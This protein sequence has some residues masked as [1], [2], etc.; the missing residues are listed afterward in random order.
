MKKVLFIAYQIPPLA[1]PAAQR[2][3]RFLSNLPSLGWDPIV[4][5]VDPACVEDYYYRDSS[6]MSY[7]GQ[8]IRIYRTMTY[9]PM[10][11]FLAR[12]KAKQP[13]EVD[14][15]ITVVPES[16]VVDKAEQRSF[17]QL[18]KDL[19]SEI[20]R[21][22]DRQIGWFPFAVFRGVELIRKYHPDVLY[23][24]GNPWTTHLVGL[25]L[26]QLYHIPWIPDFRDPWMNNPYHKRRFGFIETIERRLEKYVV[27]KA[28]F[29]ICN[30]QP[31]K[32][33]FQDT[34]PYLD[35][36]KFVHISNGFLSKLFDNLAYNKDDKKLR[37]THV[38]NL[39]SRRSPD[40]L[41]EAVSILK[42]KGTL[43]AT[44]FLLSLV[45][46]IEMPGYNESMM[47]KMDIADMV[48]IIPFVPHS[49]ALRRLARSDILLIIQPDTALQ[50]PGKLFEY[51]AIGHPILA[52][53]GEGATSDFIRQENLGVVVHPNDAQEIESALE[54]FMLRYENG[55]LPRGPAGPAHMKF[56]SRSLTQQ[57]AELFNKCLPNN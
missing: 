11:R 19:V 47:E 29:V 32:D 23:S 34:Y 17:I 14:K 1:G 57:L 4:L 7:I 13:I 18:L 27:E 35:H 42:K 54:E 33:Q 21:I 30:T 20:F 49:E 44:N 5:T 41:L 3:I 45:G 12:R 25:A 51:I 46:K 15:T 28:R 55:C 38:G 24:S 36:Y 16:N 53:T 26:S 31:L 22:P 8:D 2:H 40:G 43:N 9:N 50:I 56:E 10:D 6:L 48:E 52:L 39:Y 37:M